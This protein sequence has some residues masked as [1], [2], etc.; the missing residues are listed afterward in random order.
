[1][2]RDYIP[3]ASEAQDLARTYEFNRVVE[4]IRNATMQGYCYCKVHNLSKEMV[5]YLLNKGYRVEMDKP[6]YN[7]FF[8]SWWSK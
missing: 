6:A 7:D 5:N 8:L 2:S 4:G 3:T 1:M